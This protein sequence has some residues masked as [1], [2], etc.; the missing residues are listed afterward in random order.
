MFRLIST[1]LVVGAVA[2]CGRSR[3]ARVPLPSNPP[4]AKV[5]QVEAI[6]AASKLSLGM[7]EEDAE[8]VLAASG[9]TSPLKL[10]CSHGWTSAFIL[11]NS[12]SLAL[13]IEPKQ[14]RADGAW[15]GGLLRAADI[16][17]NGVKIVSITLTNTP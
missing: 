6:V 2:G 5:G 14:A 8:K 12:C 3:E 15:K 17:S 9:L 13:D 7:R 4:T 10:G 16:H 1:L 11:S